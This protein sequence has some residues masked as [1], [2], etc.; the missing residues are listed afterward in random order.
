MAIYRN[1][2][3]TITQIT[4]LSHIRIT[5]VQEAVAFLRAIQPLQEQVASVLQRSS[6]QVQQQVNRA[7]APAPT[8]IPEPKIV[9]EAPKVFVPEDLSTDEGFSD[10]EVETKV[11]KLKKAKEAANKDTA[12]KE[13]A[14]K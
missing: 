4:N 3:N 8:P 13:A 11:A 1:Q 6:L 7:Q 2:S 5:T 10:E 9:E 12:N 14:K